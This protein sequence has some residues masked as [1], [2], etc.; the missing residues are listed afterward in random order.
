MT[1]NDLIKAGEALA[2]FTLQM[3]CAYGVWTALSTL[4]LFL[5]ANLG[6]LKFGRLLWD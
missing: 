3:S 6:G 2:A 1:D 5:T 4:A